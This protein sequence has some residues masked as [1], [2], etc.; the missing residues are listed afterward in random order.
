M[1]TQLEPSLQIVLFIIVAEKQ[2]VSTLKHHQCLMG[3]DI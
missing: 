1:I 2:C 3:A